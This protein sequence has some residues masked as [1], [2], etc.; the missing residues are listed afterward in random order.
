MVL[1]LNN[2]EYNNTTII[3][4]KNNNIMKKFYAF[5]TLL[6]LLLAVPLGTSAQDDLT[7]ADDQATSS[8]LPFYGTWADAAQHN[9]ILIPADMLSDMENSSIESMRFYAQSSPTYSSTI[10]IQ[11]VEVSDT[12]FSSAQLLTFAN[13]TTVYS[14]SIEFEDG[15]LFFQ[16]DNEYEYGGGNL[17]IDIQ[18]TAGNW[19]GCTFTGMATD[20]AMSIYS[21][22]T[23]TNTQNFIPKT[24]FEYTPLGGDVCRKVKNLAAGELGQTEATITWSDT[25]NAAAS[26]ELQYFEVGNIAADTTTVNNI[27]GTQHNITGL[28][29]NTYYCVR[30]RAMCSDSN[31]SGWTT[32]FFRTA[33]GDMV[34]PYSEGFEGYVGTSF[35]PCWT[36]LQPHYNFSYQGDT[37]GESPVLAAGGQTGSGLAFS[38]TYYDEPD[39]AYFR[40][41]AIPLD[42]NM[43]HASFWVMQSSTPT[44]VIAG[45]MTDSADWST[46][47]PMRT[48]ES[49]N[50]QWRKYDIYSDNIPSDAEQVYLAFAVAHVSSY[51]SGAID[52]VL[53][54]ESSECRAPLSAT[55]VEVTYQSAFL[56]WELANEGDYQ[57]VVRYSTFAD[58]DVMVHDF[59]TTTVTTAA[60]E[61]DTMTLTGLQPNTTYYAWVA[62]VCGTDTIGWTPT[63]AFTT[64]QTCYPVQNLHVDGTIYEAA[65]VSW[66]YGNNGRGYAETGALVEVVDNTDSTAN[67]RTFFVTGSQTFITDLIS[68]HNYSVTVTSHCDPDSAS[69]SYTSFTTASCGTVL[70]D[71]NYNQS[72]YS[73]YEPFYYYSAQFY[74]TIYPASAVAGINVINGISYNVVSSSSTGS[75]TCD[76]Y[77]G[78]TPLESFGYEYEADPLP[79]SD[80]TLVASGVEFSFTPNTTGWVTLPFDAPYQLVGTDNVVV[81]IVQTENTVSSYSDAPQIMVFYDNT[82]SAPYCSIV[83]EDEYIDPENLGYTYT[84][85]TRP[86]I[87]FD[88]ECTSACLAPLG[89]MASSTVDSA[90]IEWIAAGEGSFV[91]SYRTFGGAWV[92]SAPTDETSYSIGDLNGGTV[93][94]FRV[95]MLCT[96]GD[97]AWSMVFNGSTQCGNGVS[98]PYVND[99]EG[100]NTYVTPACWTYFGSNPN[101]EA[102]VYNYSSYSGSKCM[103]ADVYSGDFY[104]VSP[105]LMAP[106]NTI[107]IEFYTDNYSNT[108]EA[109]IMTNP[110]DASTF[111]PM[112][113]IPSTDDYAYYSFSCAGLNAEDTIYLAFHITS[114]SSYGSYT[115]FDSVVILSTNCHRP[116]NINASSIS[117]NSVTLAW[118]GNAENNYEIRIDTI[119][120]FGAPSAQSYTAEAAIQYTIEELVADKNYFVWIRAYC[121]DEE[122]Y[123]P[124]VTYQ[125]RTPCA[126]AV[127]PMVEDFDASN[128][129]NPCWNRYSGPVFSTQPSFGPVDYYQWSIA[130]GNSYLPLSGNAMAGACYYS[131]NEW[132]VSQSVDIN[133]PA[134]FTFDLYGAAEVYNSS[135][136]SYEWGEANFDGNDRFVVG[137][138]TDYGKT[139]EPLL[140]FGSDPARDTMPL[141]ALSN[142]PM[143]F[144][145]DLN[146]YLNQDIMVAFFTGSTSGYNE[147]YVFVDNVGVQSKACMRPARIASVTTE[148]SVLVTWQDFSTDSTAFGLVLSTANTLDSAIQQVEL[149]TDTFYTFNGLQPRTDYYV[150]VRSTCD[151]TMG[152]SRAKVRTQCAVPTLPFDEDFESDGSNGFFAPECWT[153]L[154]EVSGYPALE[155]YG[156]NSEWSLLLDGGN[157]TTGAVI[158]SP[159]INAPLNSLYIDFWYYRESGSLEVGV[160]T[161]LEDSSTYQ[162]I[163][164]I[165]ESVAQYMYLEHEIFTAD[166]LSITSNGYIVFRATGSGNLDDV[167]VA[168]DNS[169]RRVRNVK[170]KNIDYYEGT[171]TWAPLD[172]DV[173]FRVKYNTENDI[174]TADSVADVLDTAAVINGLHNGTTYYVWVQTVCADGGISEPRGGK[175]TTKVSCYPVSDVNVF[176]TGY[177]VLGLE[178]NTTP[179][180]EQEIQHIM[181]TAKDITDP[182]AA[183]IEL[184]TSENEVY[185]TGLASGHIYRL[186]FTTVCDPDSSTAYTVTVVT[187]ADACGNVSG[188][189][190]INYVPF[191]PY[192]NYSFSEMLYTNDLLTNVD[193]ITSIAFQLGSGTSYSSDIKTVNVYMANT[194]LTS[195]STSSFV[196]QSQLTTV[197]SNVQVDVAHAGWKTIPLSVPFVHTAGSNL[198]VAVQN[199]TGSYTS[200]ASWK[201][202]TSTGKV[203]YSY[204][205]SELQTASELSNGYTSNVLPNIR[206]MGNCAVS[207]CH[208]PLVHLDTVTNNSATISWMAD[209]AATPWLVQYKVAGSN[210]TPW[211]DV[212]VAQTNT[213]Y[214]ITGLTDYTT[215]N[216]RVGSRCSGGD[217][218][219]DAIMSF[220]TECNTIT[221][222]PWGENFDSIANINNL[223]CWQV[224]N[225]YY[226]DINGTVASYGASGNW[227]FTTTAMDSS[228][229]VKA[230]IYGE[231]CGKWL[232]TPIIE[233]DSSAQLSFDLAL[234]DFNYADTIEELDDD[235]RFM[236]LVSTNGGH[237]WDVLAEWSSVATAD[238]ALSDLTVAAQS[239]TLLLS[240]YAG[241]SVRIGF[242][243]ESIMSGSD[244]DLHIDNVMIEHTSLVVC[245]APVI[246]SASTTTNSASMSWTG[247]AASYEVAIVEG[248]WTAPESGTATTQTSYTFDNLQPETVYAIGVRSVC[249]EQRSDWTTRTVMTQESTDGIDNVYDAA[250]GLFPNPASTSVSIVLD[251]AATVAIVDQSGRTAAS[252]TL[253]AGTTVLD[254]S[255]CASGVY[256]VRVVSTSGTSVRKL[257][258]K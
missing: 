82:Y 173:Q 166:S 160:M 184:T 232:A 200:S 108:A 257:V 101:S 30:V 159:Y 241:Q 236:V 224:F 52:N 27:T 188:N 57:Y 171:V 88:G 31:A 65:S 137:I 14:G 151:P 114:T 216:V 187:E 145:I 126:P 227:V 197:A 254:L 107:E 131:N 15:E 251:E 94:Q 3:L 174:T 194:A 89:A 172:G 79:V 41:Q 206:I 98:L 103:V 245:N 127:M 178:W 195:L 162:P 87:R 244:N 106:A 253:E 252:Y 69:S 237:N 67:I 225:G 165:D 248:A 7:V 249:G 218:I 133:E 37:V 242:Y 212:N 121:A 238:Y 148:N 235:D 208:A 84:S 5:L 68:G 183:D 201:A 91:V 209:G 77:I 144:M 157:D 220:T 199:V 231:E 233:L 72:S 105:K 250:F 111:V 118:D 140:Q 136:Y 25:I 11:M 147:N 239:F 62:T 167:F 156:H 80:M 74:Q 223:R 258:V 1:T 149:C 143:S 48:I 71:Q 204:T 18:T 26:F 49:T 211:T 115:Y 75:Y 214:T 59:D 92:T 125:F 256:Y 17:L 124:W 116:L 58:A 230:N 55:P 152:Y 51:A 6:A 46:F 40:T 153:V 47:V 21:Y 78:R 54:E 32:A 13:A 213:E 130:Q 221:E 60:T 50:S 83:S 53:I 23:T 112:A 228:R 155:D 38:T 36:L 190:S 170:V 73:V 10:T 141:S 163:Y 76:I 222:L 16:F 66:D 96:D 8:Y 63:Y 150:F 168:V 129:L 29:P 240:E 22:N 132:L 229:H 45:F 97:T 119:G 4:T 219:F 39:T 192:Y 128:M 177:T 202:I 169:C 42:P 203:V 142:E 12:S 43:V 175:F 182:T 34:L 33:C 226:I 93:Y 113:Q 95:G 56:S 154:N 198:V 61:Y 135:T 28:T 123:T 120:S 117:H 246:A 179:A 243:A 2:I 193:T 189:S 90:S 70:D 99:F 146:S 134:V 138:S 9:Q 100:Q 104:L 207:T 186:V 215:Y 110:T 185:L 64:D 158:A 86:A 24:T 139:W 196:Q 20:A 161:D 19:T 234:T 205:D 181:I 191:T 176:A 102:I 35:P 255:Q 85:S 180:P 247:T 81:T 164:T 210:T 109:G 122:T 217:T 44:P